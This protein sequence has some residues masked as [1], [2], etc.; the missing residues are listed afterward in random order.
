MMTWADRTSCS[1][2]LINIYC[3]NRSHFDDCLECNLK[4]NSLEILFDE[5]I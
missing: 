4:R 3:T 5:G 1:S 2:V